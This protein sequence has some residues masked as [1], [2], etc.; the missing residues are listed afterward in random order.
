MISLNRKNTATSSGFTIVELLIVIVVIA[1]LATITIVAFNGV[2]QRAMNTA[3]K[4]NVSSI[5][6]VI[7]L[8]HAANDLYPRNANGNY[9]VTLDN[10]C[11]LYDSSKLSTS[12]TTLVNQIQE[13]GSL[14][15][16]V[17]HINGNPAYG[18][19]YTWSS[20]FTLNSEPNPAMLVFW[21]QGTYQ[22]CNGVTG[23]ISV[24][25]NRDFTPAKYTNPKTFDNYTRCYMMFPG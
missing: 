19:Y 9:C 16:S 3:M 4:A 2:Q 10:D 13:F 24:N 17:E 5:A 18:V 25:G 21:L 12:N 11:T 22:D 1:I 20:N 23:M 15:E 14:P 8:Y 7:R 6:K